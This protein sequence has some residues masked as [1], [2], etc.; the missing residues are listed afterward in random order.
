MESAP[1]EGAPSAHEEAGHPQM[2]PRLRPRPPRQRRK[3]EE[4]RPQGGKGV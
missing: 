1:Q 2:Q 3:E 4:P